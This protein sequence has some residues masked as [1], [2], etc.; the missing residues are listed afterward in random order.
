MDTSTPQSHSQQAKDLMQQI[1]ANSP[2]PMSLDDV[3][4]G[5]DRIAARLIAIDAGK[6][7]APAP[8]PAPVPA[9]PAGVEASPAKPATTKVATAKPKARKRAAKPK[10]Q[11]ARRAPPAKPPVAE[12]PA[13][14]LEGDARQEAADTSIRIRPQL[15]AG[16]H[17]AER[18]WPDASDA[19]RAK[20][21]ALI[22]KHRIHLNDKGE[23]IPAKSGDNLVTEDGMRVYDPINGNSYTM[24]KHH[25]LVSYDMS[26]NQIRQMF[27]LTPE[28]LPK[29][30]PKYSENKSR[31]ARHLGLGKNKP[32]RLG[33][34]AQAA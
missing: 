18:I 17:I 4:N 8:V 13:V 15:R 24:L 9:P 25:L 27:R 31:Q 22:D 20:F 1:L 33:K 11:A 5:I 12:V 6:V 14:K 3:L 21:M 2:G 30:G 32:K 28:Q 23:P 7:D 10:V 26:L 16:A 29:A 34:D 19:D